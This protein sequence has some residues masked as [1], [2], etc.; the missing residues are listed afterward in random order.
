[1]CNIA[2]AILKYI[3]IEQLSNIV[4]INGAAIIAGSILSFLANIGKA[5]PSVF[6]RHAVPIKVKP[7]TTAIFKLLY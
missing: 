7:S 4:D 2:T 3:N 6:A 5:H 1:M